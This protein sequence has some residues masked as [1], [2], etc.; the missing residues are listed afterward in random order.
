M[1]GKRPSSP[2]SGRGM[3]RPPGPTERIRRNR[4]VTLVT[5]AELRQL[6]E[7]A[8]RQNRSLSSVVHEILINHMD[9]QT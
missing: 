1:A 7:I 2:S 6:A 5:D 3:G 9:G 8:D 4:V